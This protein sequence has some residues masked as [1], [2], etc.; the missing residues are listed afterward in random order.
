MRK[1]IAGSGSVNSR[2]NRR[3]P[4]GLRTLRVP[5]CGRRQRLYMD[6]TSVALS[7]RLGGETGEVALT[8]LPEELFESGCQQLLKCCVK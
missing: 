6:V 3:T 7:D 5:A 4:T 8:F 1:G 2:D